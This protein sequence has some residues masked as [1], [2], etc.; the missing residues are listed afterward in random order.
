MHRGDN[1]TIEIIDVNIGLEHD[2]NISGTP[3]VI[4]PYDLAYQFVV[5]HR[6][7]SQRRTRYRG[8]YSGETGQLSGNGTFD[9]GLI[10]TL[11]AYQFSIEIQ[12]RRE[13]I[14]DQLLANAEALLEQ[15]AKDYINNP[16]G[17]SIKNGKVTVS[18]L[19]KW[20]AYDFGNSEKGVIEHLLAYASPEQAKKLKQ[21]GSISD[22]EYD[23]SL[24]E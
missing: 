10:E 9:L 12:V 19:Y 18:K 23:W 22:T 14:L 21:I 4:I 20:F 24:N 5:R 2:I 1:Q 15:G 16:R 6:P 8:A 7:C 17:L 3:R 13:E 11:V